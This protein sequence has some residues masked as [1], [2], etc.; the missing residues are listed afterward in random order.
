MKLLV[1]GA[2]GF[3]GSHFVEQVYAPHRIVVLDKLTYAGRRRNVPDHVEEL[4]IGDICDPVIVREAMEGVDA[5]INF[6]AE[7]HVDRSIA[8]QAA[9]LQT[10]VVGTGVLLDAVRE[11][12]IERFVQ[13]STDEVYGSIPSGSA[14]E[15]WLLSPSSPYSA[16]K[17]AADLLVGAHVA[18]HGL[19]AVICRG[20]NNYGPGQF[21]EKLIPLLIDRAFHCQPLPIYGD[22]LQIRNWL[23]VDDFCRGIRRV[24]EQGRAGEVYNVGGPDE[25]TNLEVVQRI[26]GVFRSGHVG[27][28][29]GV[30]EDLIEHA[31]DRLGHDRR[32]SLDSSKIEEELGWFPRVSFGVGLEETIGWQQVKWMT[33]S[34]TA[35]N[36]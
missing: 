21:P 4:I 15:D 17:A 27:L 1:T 5:V 3:I 35:T 13:I 2:A 8:D 7:S 33:E 23:Y 29:S 25:L 6:A 11:L 20:S 32:Y 31:E 26:I 19:D 18:T 34:V 16:S 12:G 14:A 10:N 30:T 36:S 9:F 28:P 22:G 24:L